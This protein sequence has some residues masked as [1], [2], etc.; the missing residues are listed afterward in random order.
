VIFHSTPWQTGNIGGGLNAFV[1]LLPDDAWVCLRDGD[2]L[3][4]SPSWGEQVEQVVAAHG[5]A[6]S[7]IGA[8]TNRLRS[9]LQLH[10]GLF[11]DEA[12]IGRH[13]DIALQRWEEHGPLVQPLRAGVLAGMCLIFPK[14]V[15]RA[16]PF[17]ER[18]LLFDQRFCGDVRAAGGQLGVALGLYLFHLYRWGRRNPYSSVGHLAGATE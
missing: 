7:V 12:D 6:F 16:H 17:V 2:T 5:D 1:D 18:S 13:R 14:R 4:L 3:W 8:M 11:S 9:P 15:W 10:G